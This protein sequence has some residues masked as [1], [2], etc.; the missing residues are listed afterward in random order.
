MNNYSLINSNKLKKLLSKGD[1]WGAYPAAIMNNYTDIEPLFAE[2]VDFGVL[3]NL[4]LQY[5]S[6][7]IVSYNYWPRHDDSH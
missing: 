2:T 1:L 4:C 6:T 3:S 5:L 7:P